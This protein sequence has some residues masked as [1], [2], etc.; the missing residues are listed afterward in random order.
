MSAFALLTAACGT[1]V[2]GRTEHDAG[3]PVSTTLPEGSTAHT[4]DV[5]GTTRSYLTYVPPGI[6]PTAAVPLVV[7]LHGGFGSAQQAEASYGWD[8]KADAEG[9]VVA[10]PDGDGRAW[11][12]GTCC[13]RPA[14]DGVDD[15]AFITDVVTEVAEQI[16]I[17]PRRTY[18]AGMSNGAMMAE[19]L[20]CEA[21]VFS[22]AASVAGAQMVPCKDPAPISMLHI[23]G[24]ADDHVPMDGSPGHGL[25]KVPAH[26]PIVDTI[27]AWRTVDG[28][29]APATSTDGPVTT[30]TATC[31]QGRAVTLIT[32]DGAGHQWPGS[33]KGSARLQKALG[34]DPPSTALDA[35]STIW[36]FF[37][38]HPAPA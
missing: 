36:A 2:R 27:D 1:V 12:A 26:P 20:A 23:H 8:A 35:T 33:S 28:C 32:I 29:A 3:E 38:A 4:L 14:R 5:G 19:R 17:D 30:S 37:A 9:F 16:R 18:V 15:V 24:T 7:M 34:I 6:D 10:Y 21:K 25:G 22:A 13:G 11:N 31:A